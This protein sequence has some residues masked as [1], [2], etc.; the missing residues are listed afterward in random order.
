ML[1]QSEQASTSGIDR[2]KAIMLNN[3]LVFIER[4]AHRMKLVSAGPN[5]MKLQKSKW[6]YT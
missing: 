5:P 6:K 4:A 3:E 2:L 1:L